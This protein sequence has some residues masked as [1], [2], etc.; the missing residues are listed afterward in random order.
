ML[1]NFY[2]AATPW[3]EAYRDCFFQLLKPSNHEF[4]R[5]FLAC[6]L[7]VSTKHPDPMNAFAALST[8]QNNMQYS[9]DRPKSYRWFNNNTFKYYLLL[10]DASEGEDAK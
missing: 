2:I 1:F 7:V 9:T 8:K 10:H 5:D 4:L 3:Y 6:I